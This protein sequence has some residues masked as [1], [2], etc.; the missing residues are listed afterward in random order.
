[1]K[2]VSVIIPTYNRE[3]LLR[4]ALDSVAGQSYCCDEIVVVDDGSTDNSRSVV[5]EFKSHC[6]VPVRYLFQENKGPA[7]ARNL[8]IRESRYSVLAFL[9]SD[10]HWQKKKLALQYSSFAKHS[11]IMIS[12]TNERWLRRGQH[13][14]QKKKHQPG[15]GD[16]FKHCLQLCAVGMSTVMVR[17]ELFEQVGFFNEKYRCCEDY[18]MWIRTSCRY[19]FLLVEHPLTIKE[20][21]REDQ[22][23]HQYRIGM[24]KLRITS[25]LEL[26][27]GQCLSSEQKQ[28]AYDELRKK[29]FVYGKGCLKHGKTEEGEKYLDLAGWAETMVNG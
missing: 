24:D 28:M 21:G 3:K 12:H 2:G 20:G 25:I 6:P 10:D 1:M 17:K 18:D 27:Q 29:C 5:M 26:V 19:P 15:N 14:N 11:D 7:A 9:D 22:V 16:V 13:L 8:G 4:R 23:S